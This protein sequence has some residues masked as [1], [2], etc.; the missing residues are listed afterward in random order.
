MYRNSRYGLGGFFRL[1][2]VMY[3]VLNCMFVCF[4]ELF[5]C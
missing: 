5:L 2:I 4:F 1:F 3:G